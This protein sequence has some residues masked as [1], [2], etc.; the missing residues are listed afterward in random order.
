[1]L[2][3][4]RDRVRP[5]GNVDVVCGD[6]IAL[7]LA[8][9][10]VDAAFVATMLGEVPDPGACIAEIRRVLADGGTLA[11][12]ETRRDSDFIPLDALR[13]LVEP[14]AFVFVTRH[15]VGWQY[16]AQFRAERR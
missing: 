3:I 16:V 11:V 2:T 7:P 13:R 14:H 4:A 12:A 6:A 9:G 10:T 5:V 15:G 1:M 8:T